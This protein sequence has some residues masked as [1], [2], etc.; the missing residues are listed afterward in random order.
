M[1]D[2]KVKSV[3]KIEEMEDKSVLKVENLTRDYKKQSEGNKKVFHVLKGLDL[4]VRPGEFVGIIGRS[5]CG[6]TTLLKIL[7]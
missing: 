2:K 6:K 4:E 5:G 7:G 3:L 1:K